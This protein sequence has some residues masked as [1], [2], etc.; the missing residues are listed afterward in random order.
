MMAIN[1]PSSL[2]CTV[3]VEYNTRLIVSGYVKFNSVVATMQ[4]GKQFIA[5]MPS[6]EVDLSGLAEV[7]SS[8]L[9]LLLAWQRLALETQ[10]AIHFYGAP[11]SLI[12][13]ARVYGLDAVINFENTPR[14]M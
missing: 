6:I 13:L 8:A 7:D 5:S 1:N 4:A 9:S 3:K 11:R 2:A 12:D 14:K 10:K